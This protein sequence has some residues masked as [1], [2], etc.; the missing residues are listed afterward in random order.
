MLPGSS[1]SQQAAAA[2]PAAAGAASA[3]SLQP[4]GGSFT[5]LRALL[6]PG[7]KSAPDRAGYGKGT[8]G[9]EGGAAGAVSGGGVDAAVAGRMASFMSTASSPA[10]R[11]R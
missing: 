5:N 6:A 10:A 7:S 9:G 1:P 8:D 4:S 2:P 11:V 3:A